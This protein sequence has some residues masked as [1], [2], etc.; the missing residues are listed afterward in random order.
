M[1]DDGQSVGQSVTQWYGGTEVQRYTGTRRCSDWPGVHKQG[2][3]S[4]LAHGVN[5]KR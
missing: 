5:D 4:P 1:M 3:A 2:Y